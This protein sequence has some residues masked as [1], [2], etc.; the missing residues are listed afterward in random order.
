[1][2]LNMQLITRPIG[3]GSRCL[4]LIPIPRNR[5]RVRF[6]IFDRYPTR[7]PTPPDYSLAHARCMH[8]HAARFQIIIPA[9]AYEIFVTSTTLVSTPAG[10]N[11]RRLGLFALLLKKKGSFES[12]RVGVK[13]PGVGRSCELTKHFIEHRIFGYCFL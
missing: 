9:T 3:E 10:F 11:N 12:G 6:N 1:M 7:A 8:V 2:P 13:Y 5:P 4:R